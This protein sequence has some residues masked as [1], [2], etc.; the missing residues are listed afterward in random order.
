[1]EKKLGE[2]ISELGNDCKGMPIYEQ[3]H[4]IG[5][6]EAKK[7][8]DI[9]YGE[10]SVPFRI[11]KYENLLEDEA[12]TEFSEWESIDDGIVFHKGD[13]ATIQIW[14]EAYFVPRIELTLP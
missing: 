10:I 3:I 6:E 8:F 11:N 7:I 1:M 9:A 4:C 13:N 12:H 14:A 5:A 2:R